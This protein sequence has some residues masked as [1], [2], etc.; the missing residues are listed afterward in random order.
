MKPQNK[1]CKICLFR[2]DEKGRY[3]EPKAVRKL[4]VGLVSQNSL[5][6]H[7]TM[8]KSKNKKLICRGARD[9][10]LTIFHRL[11]VIDEPTDEAWNEAF[12]KQQNRGNQSKI[13]GFI[14]ES[15]L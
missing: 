9:Y 6:C 4:E 12:L 1:K 2:T 5:I 15:I 7:S 8:D 11:G 3:L 14:I 10:Q 13:R